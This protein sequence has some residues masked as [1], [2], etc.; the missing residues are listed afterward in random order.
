MEA[1]ARGV[2]AIREALEAVEADPS[3]PQT[4]REKVQ[5]AFIETKAVLIALEGSPRRH[6]SISELTQLLT[7]E[8]RESGTRYAKRAKSMIED[9][10]A[11]DEAFR[12]LGP[13]AHDPNFARDMHDV[14]NLIALVPVVVFNCIN[15]TCG[16]PATMCGVL[17]GKSVPEM[18]DGGFF[19]LFWWTT[20]GYF[21][22]DILWVLILPHCVKSPK[23]I[24]QHHVVTI[25]YIMI[26]FLYPQYGWLM[27]A[28]MI[29]EVNTWLIIARRYFN[30]R[31][32]KAFSPGVPLITSCRLLAV[33]IPFYLTWFVIR[34]G[35][36]PFLLLVL[37]SEWYKRWQEVGS[38]FNILLITPAMQSVFIYLNLKWTVDLAR[39]KMKGRGASKGL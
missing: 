33:S 3:T 21:I 9:H 25:A 13:L 39:S 35:V 36:Y 10:F 14:F 7:D 20:L 37:V 26:P 38:P 27:G 18:W 19:L 12:M 22:A 32:L 23:V 31:G 4:V 5:Q 24:L 29:V 34:L 1:A 6:H 30:R 2:K 15:W 11:I 16:E 28:C 8:I 17:A